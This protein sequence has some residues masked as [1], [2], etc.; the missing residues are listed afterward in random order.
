M[1]LEFRANCLV[2]GLT[3]DRII[4]ATEQHSSP[5]RGERRCSNCGAR[6]S[7]EIY[8]DR[9]VLTRLDV[10][11]DDTSPKE[12]TIKPELPAAPKVKHR[13]W[14]LTAYL[15]LAIVANL[16]IAF[17]NLFAN[18]L[19]E[20]DIPLWFRLPAFAITILAAVCYAM[21]FRWKKWAFNGIVALTVLSCILGMISRTLLGILQPLVPLAILYG[22][23]QIGGAKKGWTQLE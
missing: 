2:C 22:V 13:H 1:P 17:S 6:Y 18:V 7:Y 16:I 4:S 11:A 19:Y 10:A 8:S 15:V 23:L 5:E 21:L 12:T 3:L 9:L 20:F 14:C